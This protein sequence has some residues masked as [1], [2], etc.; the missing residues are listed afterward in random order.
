MPVTTPGAPVAA[1][2]QKPIQRFIKL[3]MPFVVSAVAVF[4]LVRNYDFSGVAEL[5][6][7]EMAA[8]FVPALLT[9]GVL[10]LWIDAM[11]LRC[12]MSHARSDFTILTAARVKAASYLL[13]LIHIALGAGTLAVLLRKRGGVGLAEAAGVVVLL[14][15][16]DLGMLLSM[17]VVGQTL[18]STTSVELQFGAILAVIAVITGGFAL[19]R[20][21]FSLGPLDGIRQLDLFRAARTLETRRLVELALLR[22]AFVFNFQ[23][24]GLFSFMAFGITMP[25][26]ALLVNFSTV[27]LVGTLPAMAGIGPAQVAM[28]EVFKDFGSQEALLACA[29]ALNVGMNGMRLAIGLFFAGEFSREAYSAVLHRDTGDTAAEGEA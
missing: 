17:V 22:F 6:N 14:L 28:V 10:S 25:F 11:S 7:L 29:I 26:G 1:P 5:M 8:I 2:P 20:A 15:M 21:P 3:S 4:Y 23:L 16:F 19:L 27:A 9:Y 24:L 13:A 18:V 12:S